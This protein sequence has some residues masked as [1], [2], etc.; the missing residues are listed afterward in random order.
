MIQSSLIE[1]IRFINL[2]DKFEYQRT[3]K[4]LFLLLIILFSLY[5]CDNLY[6]FL[7]FDYEIDRESSEKN[8]TF[9]RLIR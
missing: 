1:V 7:N 2:E 8:S 6:I 9:S 3:L 4:V 5:L